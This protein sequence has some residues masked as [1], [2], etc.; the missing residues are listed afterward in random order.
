MDM[1]PTDCIALENENDVVLCASVPTY[2]SLVNFIGF[3]LIFLCDFFLFYG[4]SYYISNE[5]FTNWI[6]DYC[7]RDVR[8][9]I[10]CVHWTDF[11]FQCYKNRYEIIAKSLFYWRYVRASMKWKPTNIVAGI[12]IRVICTTMNELKNKLNRHCFWCKNNQDY[13]ILVEIDAFLIENLYKI[14][15]Q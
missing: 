5:S 9:Y 8:W 7:L 4:W 11:I 12:L 13:G 15:C 6:R 14:T 3:K 10:C 2:S 1:H